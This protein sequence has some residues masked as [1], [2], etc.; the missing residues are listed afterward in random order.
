MKFM[1]FG[2]ALLMSAL[3]AA[4]VFSVTSC[5]E[6]YAVGYLYVTGTVTAQ[7]STNGIING[8]SIDHNTGMLSPLHGLP[9]S[10]GGANPVRA[11][12]LSGS[13]F[14]Y[15]LNR[16]VSADGQPCTT[17]DPCQNS[18]ISVFAVG[19]NGIL[20]QQPEQ[21]YSQGINPFRLILDPSGQYLYV[22]DH[23]SI[24]ADGINPATA[25]NPNPN[26][27]LALGTGI[28]CG[29]ITAFSIEQG[30]G[31]LSLIV[32]GQV[33]AANGAPLNYFPVPANP[34]DF[35]ESTGYFLTLYG[36]TPS[37]TYPYTGG[38]SIFPYAFV[39]TGQLNKNQNGTQPLN[40]AEG[41]AIVPGGTYLYVLDNEPISV[42]GVVVSQS[43]IL[44]YTVGANGYLASQTGGPVADDPAQ[45]NPIYL[46]VES[47]GKWLYVANQ[48]DNNTQT[49]NAESGIT[50][51]IIDPATH[52]LREIP[53]LPFSTGA[54]PQCLVE[55]PSDQYFYTANFMDSTVTGNSVDQNS[56]LLRPLSTS[57]NVPNS[58]TLPGPATWCLMNGRV[59]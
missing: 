51:Y 25:T 22:L 35:L 52:Q 23:D 2:K 21:F 42:N 1:K 9:V 18:N 16:G 48:G 28:T 10:S 41:T 54:G 38:T 15:V 59:S 12:L 6:S 49:G 7:T 47:K 44:P 17:A 26:C 31:R 55:D 46:A 33:S 50:G 4:L 45:A 40:I 27:G 5:I 37:T 11:V 8:F 3:S 43:Q 29:D 58:Y 34:V 13:R 19:G 56:G 39:S 20:A 30:T 24:G 14:L 57:H 32:N 36:T 53:G